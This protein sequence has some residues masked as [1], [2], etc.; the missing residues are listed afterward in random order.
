MKITTIAPIALVVASA[1]T[2][3][4]AAQ[5]QDA[6]NVASN[7]TITNSVSQ[8]TMS[9]Q[10]NL[11]GDYQMEEVRRII[12]PNGMIKAR[13]RQLYRGVP[14]FGNAITAEPN[15]FGLMQA[16]VG[17]VLTEIEQDLSS[18]KPKLSSKDALRLLRGSR[19]ASEKNIENEKSELF[20][21]MDENN[22]ARL[23]YQVSFFEASNTPRRPFAIIDANTGEFIQKWEGLAH[24]LVGTGP[25]GNNKTGQYE[26]GTD[27]GYLD[28]QKSGNTCTMNNTNVK[29][30]NLNHGT[31]GSSAFSYTCP[32]NTVKQINGAFAPL[33][34]AHFFG[35]VVFNMYNDWYNTAPLSFQLTMRVHYGNSYQ[36]AF[37][38]GSSMT[39]G[40][41]GSIFYPLVSLDVSAHEVSHGFTEQNSG[42]IYSNQSGGINEAFSDMAG[43]AAE[44]F[45]QGSND[46]LV[47]AQ[48]FKGNGSLRYFQ[49]PTQDGNSIGHASNYTA[50]MDVHY[51]SGVFNRA[52]YL[53]AT[54]S[55]WNT[56]KAFEIMVRANQLYWTQNATYNT[57]ACGVK[58]AASDLGYSTADVIAAFNTV[59]VDA[60]CGGGTDPDPSG[61]LKNGVALTGLSGSRGNNTFYY[62]DVPAGASNLQVKISG[63]SGDADLYLKAG[64]VVSTSNYDCRP[65]LNGNNET[66]SVAAPQNVR[67]SIML[68]GWS[69]YSGVSLVAS[70][71]N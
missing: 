22:I 50:G 59:G 70:Y 14:V 17:Q 6:Q 20:I 68:R 46:W 55:G 42:L 41:G 8:A 33:N 5:W 4:Q 53:L 25:G 30:V 39:F 7:N 67:Y 63:G 1:F 28:V 36:N 40:D 71:N 57:A 61:G 43:E 37:W 12:L 15:N 62:V 49:D 18:I 56:R 54:T 69:N 60:T 38:N 31:S 35:G 13:Y 58:N 16:G 65:Y 47:G 48:I 19:L 24:A 10:L 66:C 27:F 51:S 23:V 44:Y 52:F 26:Y 34:D 45:M 3:A 32:R 11:S 21:F 64:G 2:T 9:Q 29:T